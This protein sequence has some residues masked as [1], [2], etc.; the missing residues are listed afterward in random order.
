MSESVG[1]KGQL[2]LGKETTPGTPVAPTVFLAFES[3]TFKNEIERAESAGIAGTRGRSKLRSTQTKKRPGGGFVL[4]GTKVEELPLLLELA[5]GTFSG[6]SLGSTALAE[7]LPSFT[8]EIDKVARRATYA[9]CKMGL[10]RL[11]S[12]SGD[13]LLK[14]EAENIV[15]MSEAIS[16]DAA[17]TPVYTETQ[18]PLVHKDATLTVDTEELHIEEVSLEIENTLD[19]D[20]FRNSQTRLAVP[21]LDR[22]VGGAIT[23][24]WNAD[25]YTHALAKFYSGT[26]A[27]VVV[28]W[29]DGT[30]TLSVSL[31]YCYFTGE[32]PSIPGR[33]VMTLSLP[34]EAKDSADGAA[35]A[36]QITLS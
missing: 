28:S 18:R 12:S 35:D 14:L 32:T 34:F 3:E 4:S 6:G 2:G 19:D 8:V 30:R 23:S 1:Y 25:A 5:F 15:A 9:G 22:R 16:A 31:P 24:S 13:Q 26:T 7:A 11:A 21:E 29:T 17:T 20:L 36:I 10:L 27:A 33:E